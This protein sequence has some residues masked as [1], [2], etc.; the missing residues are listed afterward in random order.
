MF[1]KY[2]LICYN[3]S[4]RLRENYLDEYLELQRYG[5]DKTT[6]IDNGYVLSGAF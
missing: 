6:L 3:K 1:D 5:R 4:K 2:F